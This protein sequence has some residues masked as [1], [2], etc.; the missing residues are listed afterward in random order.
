MSNEAGRIR[1]SRLP[2]RLVVQTELRGRTI[3]AH[4]LPRERALAHLA[5]ATNEHDARVGKR[6]EDER[7]CVALEQ[8][9]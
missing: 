1:Q 8:A 7:S 2:S 5:G 3:L 9:S 6:L 4:Y